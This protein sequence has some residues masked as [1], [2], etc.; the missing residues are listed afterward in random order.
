M[1]FCVSSLTTTESKQESHLNVLTI[2]LEQKI[3]VI[4]QNSNFFLLFFLLNRALVQVKGNTLAT[5]SA[6]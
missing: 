3:R 1:K 2:S 6:L 5:L 4:L